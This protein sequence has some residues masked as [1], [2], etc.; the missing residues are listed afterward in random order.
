AATGGDAVLQVC[1][2]G[3]GIAPELLPRVFDLFVQGQRSIDR[4]AGGLGI[5]LTL[6]RRLVELHG[7]TVAASSSPSGSCFEVRLPLVE[8]VQPVPAAH[9]PVQASGLR[10]LVVEDNPDA[11]R[12]MCDMLA[13]DGHVVR[14]EGDGAAGL[15]ALLADWPD[16]AIVDIG[17]PGIDGFELALR[18]R[19]Q[20]FSGRLIALSGYGQERDARRALKAGFDAHLVKPVG[21]DTLRQL[22]RET[23]P[24]LESAY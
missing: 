5:G 4:R 10:V 24:V 21:V 14:G 11:L 15:A 17:L 6:V 2:E 8:A 12:S 22:M 18:A 19:S 20:G 16:L 3:D 13:L 7:G 1:D 9:E 23:Q